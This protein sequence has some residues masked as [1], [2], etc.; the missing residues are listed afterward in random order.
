MNLANDNLTS[1]I[2]TKTGDI[3]NNT[4]ALK[5]AKITIAM[6]SG[7]AMAKSSSEVVGIFLANTP[8]TGTVARELGTQMV[9]A[10]TATKHK[11]QNTKDD[12]HDIRDLPIPKTATKA[13]E[14]RASKAQEG[15][16][17]TQ[18]SKA[19]HQA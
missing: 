11:N 7:T 13:E 17:H 19:K 6:G 12:K 4:H 16:Y 14:S 9:T 5:K 1:I 8:V 18:T 3:V 15:S 2:T 10:K